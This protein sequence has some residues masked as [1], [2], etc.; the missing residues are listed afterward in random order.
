MNNKL[1][2]GIV[3]IVAV[4]VAGI[5]FINRG[6]QASPADDLVQP[7]TDETSKSVEEAS[8]GG[9][10]L[11][12]E[13]VHEFTIS[14]S[15]FKFDVPKITI[16]EGDTV[17]ITFKNTQGTHDFVLDEFGVKTKRL[18]VGEEETVEFMADQKGTFNFY[19]SVPGH[20][21]SGMEGT[22]VVE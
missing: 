14:A 6:N 22:L 3:V 18:A 5:L 19:C 10:S 13:E 21:S 20:R 16:K 11:V 2:L 1:L 9:E 4:A 15:P 7:P 17:S 12:D 8:Q